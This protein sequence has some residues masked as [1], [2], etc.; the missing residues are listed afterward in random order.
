MG[1]A[2]SE[3]LIAAGKWIESINVAEASWPN[4]ESGWASEQRELLRADLALGLTDMNDKLGESVGDRPD[5]AHILMDFDIDH[6][7][8]FSCLEAETLST[9]HYCCLRN[10]E[11]KAMEMALRSLN[12]RVSQSSLVGWNTVD[13]PFHALSDS[14]RETRLGGH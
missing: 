11:A 12:L 4:D 5:V 9:P 7:D 13:Y 10:T 1:Y 14:D 2:P 8:P 6:A 3:M